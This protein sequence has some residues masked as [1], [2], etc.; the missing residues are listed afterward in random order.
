MLKNL[1]D[2]G[3]G[4]CTLETKK[5]T[6]NRLAKTFVSDWFIVRYNFARFQNLAR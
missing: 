3:R 2:K 6:R 5:R 1:C 4:F